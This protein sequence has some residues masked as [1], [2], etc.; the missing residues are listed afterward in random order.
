MGRSRGSGATAAYRRYGSHAARDLPG[1]DLDRTD[2]RTG[3]FAGESDAFRPR[4]ALGG[5]TLA[6]RTAEETLPSHMS[7]TGTAN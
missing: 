3:A 7:R 5:H 6:E 1:D 2:R 4:R